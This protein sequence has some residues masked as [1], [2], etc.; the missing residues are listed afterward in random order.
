L[1]PLSKK[2]SGLYLQTGYT[3][4][5]TFLLKG[6]KLYWQSDG[7]GEFEMKPASA[8]SFFIEEMP[9]FQIKFE[10]DKKGNVIKGYFIEAGVAYEMKKK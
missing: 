7:Y 4:P 10:L 8:K 5:D 1:F 3:I 2:V 6:N 9:D